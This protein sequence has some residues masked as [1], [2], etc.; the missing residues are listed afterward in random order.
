MFPCIFQY[1]RLRIWICKSLFYRVVCKILLWVLL[2]LFSKK[3][4][5]VS[6][7]QKVIEFEQEFYVAG[8]EVDGHCIRYSDEASRFVFLVWRA[9]VSSC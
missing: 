2:R 9:T 4:E 6:I 5:R 8:G 1:R 3:G 7:E